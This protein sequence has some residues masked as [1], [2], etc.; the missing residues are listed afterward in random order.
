MNTLSI[1]VREAVQ[2]SWDA[3][4]EKGTPVRFGLS[5]WKASNDQMQALREKVFS[6]VPPGLTL[7]EVLT[8]GSD[9]MLLAVYDRGTVGL[10]GPTRANIFDESR[11]D[12]VEFLRNMGRKPDR[13]LSGGTY[14]YGK[15]AFYKASTAHTIC[16]HTRCR[17]RGDLESRFMAAALGGE[18]ENA[19]AGYTGRHW[20]GR[21]R[22]GIVDPLINEEADRIAESIG[23]PSFEGGARG[24][25]ILVIRPLVGDRTGA[26]AL[27]L[28]IETALWYFW[29]KMLP[30]DGAMPAMQFEAALDGEEVPFPRPGEFPPLEGFIQALQQVRSGPDAEGNPF[31]TVDD[32][33]CMRPKQFLGTLVL[34][35]F[36]V[37]ARRTLDTGPEGDDESVNTPSPVE[38]LCHHVALM[39]Q[40]E[41]V[42]KYLAGPPLASD[43][44]EYAGVFKT[45]TE[46]DEIFAEAEPPT[47]DDW[48][49]DSLE[50]PW[51][52]TFVRVAHRRI[53]NLADEFVMPPSVHGDD[54]ELLPL[55]GFAGELGA[56]LPGAPGPDPTVAIGSSGSDGRSGSSGGDASTGDDKKSVGRHRGRPLIRILGEGELT[57]YADT[58]ALV[59][60][61][62]VEH[63][64]GSEGTFVKVRSGAVLD[65]GE[66]ENDP[67]AGSAGVSVLGWQGPGDSP[68]K[69]PSSSKLFIPVREQGSWK[70]AV[71]IVDDAPAAVDLRAEARYEDAEA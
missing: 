42:V 15:A 3:R 29:P 37:K 30:N 16:V 65:G 57:T 5:L 8:S 38:G 54:R 70:V 31:S 6:E 41:L 1:L 17:H 18:Y 10:G 50:E 22:D 51:H 27:N 43:Q 35:R 36:P 28:M 69:T 56:L 23:L 48:I 19:S 55:G 40:P 2:N 34:Q 52:K 13:E 59:V 53:K 44:I 64:P 58:D 68:Q 60:R 24:T 62:E 11:R 9:L 46:V 32:V 14:G 4:A 21:D 63:A 33:W 67:P 25:S 71:S 39:R 20:W 45:D 7:D 66:I 12:F 49:P 61:F 26:Q 47:H